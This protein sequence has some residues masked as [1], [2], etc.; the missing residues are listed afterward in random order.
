[1]PRA[2][3]D[4]VVIHR[5]ELGGKEREFVEGALAAFQFNRVVTPIVA[6]MSD[7]DFMIVFTALLTFFFPNIIIPAGVSSVEEVVTAI[8]EGVAQGPP[9][10][11]F[12]MGPIDAPKSLVE[13]IFHQLGIPFYEG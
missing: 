6:G 5:I 1:M 10:W 12:D 9:D 4:N 11:S 3:A 2:K 7:K 13:W 8:I